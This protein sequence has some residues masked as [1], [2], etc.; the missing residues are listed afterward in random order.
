MPRP[1]T[2]VLAL[3]ALGLAIGLVSTFRLGAVVAAMPASQIF[4]EPLRLV[5]P[6]ATVGPGAA[7]RAEAIA[8][9]IDDPA[10]L[11]ARLQVCRSPEDGGAIDRERCLRAIDDALTAAPVSGE[12]WLFRA[13]MLAASGVPGEA[14]FQ[15]L[16]NSF[17]TAP[18]EGWIASERVML[19]L[20]L[21][22]LLPQDL[23]EQTRSDLLLVMGH[24]NLS[25]LL[26][27]TYA[28]D[29][30][31]RNAGAEA[32]RSLPADVLYDFV[33]MARNAAAALPVEPDEDTPP[34]VAAP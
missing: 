10:L 11:R 34:D 18:R 25:R 23:R 27:E 7:R 6:G 13:K 33:G 26:A 9:R 19:E 24:G 32:L 1:R 21:Y 15:S 8:A 14:F 2:I 16:R 22:P 17:L 30:A 3:A 20:R 12:L 5:V 28:A 4:D 31:M 29:L